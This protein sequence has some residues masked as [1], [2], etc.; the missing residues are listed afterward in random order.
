MEKRLSSI[1]EK[2]ITPKTKDRAKINESSEMWFGAWSKP[3]L[4]YVRDE[5]VLVSNSWEFPTGSPM[6]EDIRAKAR[7]RGYI[8]A[9]WK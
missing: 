1:V 9:D 6:T 8:L 5:K 4:I 2:Y 7:A 3:M